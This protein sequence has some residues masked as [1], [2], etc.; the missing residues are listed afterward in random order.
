MA[1]ISYEDTPERI[2]VRLGNMGS[3][4][5]DLYVW[6]DPAPLWYG[7]ADQGGGSG[8]APQWRDLWEQIRQ[9]G[10]KLLIVDPASAALAD[11]STTE[12][13]PV[14]AFLRGMTQEA[15][16]AGCGVLI[17]AHNTKA[18][19]IAI[20]QGDLETGAADPVAGSSVWY[21][22]ARGVLVLTRDRLSK[23]D[24]ILVLAK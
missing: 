18:A 3:I 19:R 15:K 9:I 6:P 17:V 14:R 23:T 7:E 22:G 5:D 12:T 2:A 13:G 20:A 24:R 16:R 1:L 10:A 8:P 4:P 11:V 21:D